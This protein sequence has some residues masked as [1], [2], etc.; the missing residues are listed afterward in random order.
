MSENTPHQTSDSKEEV[1]SDI[2]LKEPSTNIMDSQKKHLDPDYYVRKDYDQHN[3]VF[4]ES[5]E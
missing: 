2:L 4:P 1:V 5:Q 3:K